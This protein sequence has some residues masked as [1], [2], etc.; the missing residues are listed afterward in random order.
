MLQIN[1]K[2]D[3]GSAIS[4]LDDLGRRQVPFARSLAI[5]RTAQKVREAEQRE[6]TRVFDRPTRYTLNSVYMRPGTKASPTAIVWLKDDLRGG[7]APSNYLEPQIY[8]GKRRHKRFEGALR[9][10]GLIPDKAF[11]VPGAGAVLDAYGNMS[12]GQIKQILSYFSVAERS[13][14]YNANSTP[15]TKAKLKKGS[16]RTGRRGIEYFIA[17]PNAP[18]GSRAFMRTKHLAPGIYRKT[19]FGF[20]SSIQPVIIYVDNAFY[21]KRWDF[22]GVAERVIDREFA[23]EFASAINYALATA[24]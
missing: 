21:K 14:G 10:R 12:V 23:Q 9:S 5:N 2:T 11:A 8:G 3:I 13:S 20:G 22:F 17:L 6:I 19:Y 18:Q 1:L 16:A 4:H 7:A 24:K 15:Q